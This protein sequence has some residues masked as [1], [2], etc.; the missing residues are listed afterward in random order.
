M[1]RNPSGIM[2]SLQMTGDSGSCIPIPLW[3]LLS[4]SSLASSQWTGFWGGIDSTGATGFI[5]G[6]SYNLG[7]VCSIGIIV[8]NIIGE[9]E[10]K[11]LVVGCNWVESCPDLRLQKET[12][13]VSVVLFC[14][15]M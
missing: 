3:D 15:G 4:F 1:T 7:V 5:G 14:N 11:F 6:C 9:I 13:Q 8:P 10:V 12:C 2:H